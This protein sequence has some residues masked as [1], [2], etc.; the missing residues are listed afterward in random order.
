MKR[1][2]FALL[3]MLACHGGG[4]LDIPA[5]RA[6]LG[7]SGTSATDANKALLPAG[8]STP[9]LHSCAADTT[10][11]YILELFKPG[12]IDQPQVLWHWA[13]VVSGPDAKKP[14]LR[15]P[16]FSVAG[17]VAGTDD[18][19]TD[20]LA[21]HPFGSDVNVDVMPDAAYA[22]LAYGFMQSSALH[23]EVETRAF[24]RGALGYSPAPNDRVL[25]R[26]AWILDCGHPPY[27]AE[28][29]PPS[30]VSYARPLDAKTT[31][32][33]AL[34]EPYRSS[35]FYSQDA[36]AAVQVAN[37][38]RFS[39]IGSKPFPQAMVEAI[40][41]AVVA[42]TNN[43]MLH[44]LLEANRFT[45]LDFLVCAPLPRP[46]GAKLSATWRFTA[47]SGISIG[48]SPIESA[49]CVRFTATMGSDY[50]PAP[51]VLKTSAWSWQDLSDTASG[52]VGSSLDVRAAIIQGFPSAA[53]APALQADHPPLVDAYDPLAPLPGA[54]QDSPSQIV[55]RADGQP[56][57]FYGRVRVAW[58]G[59]GQ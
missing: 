10:R 57:P 35:Q 40:Q 50:A 14:T 53:N 31:V 45:S 4:G 39:L 2:A 55:S 37:T 24:P 59:A 7:F 9:D 36:N 11:A 8:F 48:A 16:E 18:S 46:A 28:M 27:Y 17:T 23:T 6:I 29:H 3:P 15:Q 56:F 5:D 1:L 51:V 13:P 42:G 34:F 25:M 21:D 58:I 30:F 49:G 26:G 38:S 19:T 43:L 52:Q 54:D 44:P 20:V 12:P 33:V 32:A 47:R 22:F 41:F